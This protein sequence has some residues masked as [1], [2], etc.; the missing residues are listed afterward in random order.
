MG[1]DPLRAMPSER[2]PSVTCPDLVSQRCAIRAAAARLAVP[3]PPRAATGD[4]LAEADEIATGRIRFN[5]LQPPE[6]PR[7]LPA[8]GRRVCPPPGGLP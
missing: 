8:I 4:D 3:A 5:P 6:I 2:N 7:T 1:T